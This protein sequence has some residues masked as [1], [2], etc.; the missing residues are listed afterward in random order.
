[1]KISDLLQ[2][3]I[4][5]LLRTR[6]RS[7]LTMFGIIIGIA[8]VIL[9]LSIGESAQK[10][11]IAQISGF[12]SDVLYMQSGTLEGQTNNPSPF[13]EQVLKPKD[14]KAIKRQTWVEAASGNI[15]QTDLLQANGKN[16][17]I[18][19]TGCGSDDIIIN[20]YKMREGA[21]ITQDEYDSHARVAVIGSNIEENFF[22]Q[23]NAL[24]QRI[25]LGSNS[26]RVIG[27]LD[28]IGTRF[29]QNMD[30]M[31][32]IPASTMMDL[33]SYNTFQ[34]IT[35]K[36]PLPLPEAKYRL[37]LLMRDQHNINNPEGDLSKDDF[38]VSTQEDAIKI[39]SQIT[40]VL[41][42]LLA[43]IAAISL[44]VGGIG[45]MNIMFVSVTERIKEIGLRKAIGAT[46]QQVL[47]QFLAESIILTMLGGLGGILLGT[48]VSWLAIQIIL[49]Y[50]SGWEFTISLNGILFG[51]IVSTIVGI[52][53]GYAPALRA[54]RLNPIEALRNND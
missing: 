25:K 54:A 49:L 37:E 24:N 27:V 32:F 51:V 43:A 30:D 46:N 28:K 47:N 41:Q 14:L 9:A 36:T 34:F 38:Y 15:F 39:V 16:Q 1:M 19:V 2:S 33:Y 23:G 29:F 3:A 22:G 42:I 17:N 10:F 6:N 20:N 26:Y 44:V 48:F 50:Q 5:S 13:V 21:Y 31:V 7:L 45:I 52:V 11:I 40:N 4:S 53:F 8:A 35:I 12:G 18:S